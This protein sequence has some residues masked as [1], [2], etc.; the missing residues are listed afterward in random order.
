M[1]DIDEYVRIGMVRALST[2]SASL[3]V[4]TAGTA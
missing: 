1:Q 3:S 2:S 4:L